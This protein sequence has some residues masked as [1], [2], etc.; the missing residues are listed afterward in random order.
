MNKVHFDIPQSTELLAFQDTQNNVG[1][2]TGNP[3]KI[4]VLESYDYPFPFRKPEKA[5]ERKFLGVD[6][7]KKTT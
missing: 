1:K 4:R 5:A 3:F 7:Q 6:F 2:P